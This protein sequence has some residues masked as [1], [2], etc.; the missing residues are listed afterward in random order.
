MATIDPPEGEASEAEAEG[1]DSF[2]PFLVHSAD[3]T[4]VADYPVGVFLIGDFDATVAIPTVVVTII[5]SQLLVAV[6]GTAWHRLRN[7]RQLPPDC[8]QRPIA[9]S[10]A[11]V[12][13]LDREIVEEGIDIKVWLGLLK[14]SYLPCLSF[15]S[16]DADHFTTEF[17]T[18]QGDS[19]YVPFADGLVAA[20]DE[21]FSFLTGRHQDGHG[22]IG[23]SFLTS[24]ESSSPSSSFTK[25]SSCKSR[26]VRRWVSWTRPSSSSSSFGQRHRCIS[27]SGTF[28][29]LV[30]DK[31]K[32]GDAPGARA[33]QPKKV[34]ILGDSEEE[35]GGADAEEVAAPPDGD[36][37]SVA[38]VKLT[39]IMSSLTKKKKPR[40]FEELLDDTSGIL[41]Q[42][43]SSSTMG[44][45]RKHAT[46]LRNL[47]KAMRESPGHI[48][49]VIESR[50]ESDFGAPEIA[51]GST[52]HAGT[53]RGWTEHRSK[54]PN[55]GATVRTAWTIAG[56]LDSLRLGRVEEAQA[57]L[58]L[59][60]CQL[61]QVAVDRGQWVLAVL[62]FQSSCTSRSIGTRT[63]PFVANAVGRSLHASSKRA[64]RVHRK[65]PEAGEKGGHWRRRICE[66]G[67][68]RGKRSRQE[69]KEERTTGG[70]LSS[71]Q[72]IVQDDLSPPRRLHLR[73]P[74]VCPLECVLFM[75][76]SKL[77]W[78]VVRHIELLM[79][80][81]KTTECITAE[82]MGRA[83]AKVENIDELLV[84]LSTF[85]EGVA[86]TFEESQPS[87]SGGGWAS[88]T[89]R[90]FARGLQR[91]SRT[92]ICGTVV[93]GSN[94]AAKPL[95]ASRLEFR[96]VP[97]FDSSPFLDDLG[98]FIYEEPIQAALKPH[99]S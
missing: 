57:K 85:E 62:L 44:G 45:S 51:P 42:S 71:S 17:K 68:W 49:R 40:S 78:K 2:K 75:P 64:R 92:E 96:G 66:D 77:Q 3:G 67:R 21:K 73:R 95:K 8:L 43:S 58:S 79:R 4:V 98:R 32:L 48:Y 54:I 52:K 26:Q 87:L 41:D 11:G 76:L 99:E 18:E 35:E 24:F 91:A 69:R 10:V 33:R 74:R 70:G 25:G 5:D 59:F 46:L 86:S 34:D 9:I 82:N 89:K 47:R 7:S 83:A 81:W 50:M 93:A 55:L 56:A 19:G 39:N 6:P 16:V 12:K 1:I 15:D 61:D 23:Q 13:E 60:L 90:I 97:G 63:Y 88:A 30:K 37:V 94:M 80:A 53:F 27:S 14:N 20:A 72:S 36:P 29:Y 84:R 65:T 38:V 22:Q 28:K 31:P